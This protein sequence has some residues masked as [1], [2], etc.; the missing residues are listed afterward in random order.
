MFDLPPRLRCVLEQ[1]LRRARDWVWKCTLVVRV[2]LEYWCEEIRLKT[3]VSVPFV[4][5]LYALYST[6]SLSKTYFDA[7]VLPVSTIR[8]VIILNV[9][10]CVRYRI[11]SILLMAGIIQAP[12]KG[13]SEG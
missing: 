6:T 9:G 11:T 10:L 1:L 3:C 4:P 13:V 12:K 8:V 5:S 2:G 7:M